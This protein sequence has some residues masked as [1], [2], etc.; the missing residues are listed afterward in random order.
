[1]ASPGKRVAIETDKSE[2]TDFKSSTEL[3]TALVTGANRGLGLEFTK[4]LL[5]HKY[6]VIA[7]CR[8]P[9]KAVDLLTL[10]KEFGE[11]TVMIEEPGMI[12]TDMSGYDAKAKPLK[13]TVVTMLK[14]VVFNT[15]IQ[16]RPD[17]FWSY[18]GAKRPW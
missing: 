12:R 15:E 8:S 1:M 3:H 4:Q 14:D 2:E 10:Q 7:C 16:P 17:C 9:S 5:E 6:K 13:E 18:S 11:E